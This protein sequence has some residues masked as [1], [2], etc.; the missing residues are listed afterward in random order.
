MDETASRAPGLG[1]YVYPGCAA[2]TRGKR[3]AEATA[4]LDEA[5]SAIRN[6]DLVFTTYSTLTA[7]LKYSAAREFA[8]FSPLLRPFPANPKK[9]P[10]T[11]KCT[12]SALVI[13]FYRFWAHN[14]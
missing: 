6:A 8:T 5:L 2:L 4:A 3:G 13:H 11:K 12:L 9:T 14:L 1:V 7:D 10:S